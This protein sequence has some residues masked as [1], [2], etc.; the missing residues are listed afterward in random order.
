MLAPRLSGGSDIG[1]GGGGIEELLG[2][3]ESEEVAIG[4]SRFD[5]AV[6]DDDEAVT[7]GESETHGGEVGGG[8]HAEG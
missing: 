2:A 5:D 1:G 3:L 8:S 4:V 6:G 7:R